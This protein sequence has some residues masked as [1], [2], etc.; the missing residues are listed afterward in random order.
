MM[1]LHRITPFIIGIVAAIGFALFFKY[2]SF[3][4]LW[5]I[6]TLVVEVVLFAHLTK[7]NIGKR[8]TLVLFGIP[9]V[10]ML[11]G[12][13]M[14]FFLQSLLIKILFVAVVS[15]LVFFFSEHIFYYLYLP[16]KYKA[17]AIEY[18]TLLI[19]VLCVFFISVAGFGV[20]LFLVAP[21]WLLALVFIILIL[22]II[23]SVMWV[24]KFNEFE[25]YFYSI[26]GSLILTELFISIIYLP[27]GFFTNAA[28]LT[29][30]FYLFI[31]LIRA[32]L[33]D[34][35]SKIVIRRYLLI[36]LIMLLGICVTS[37]WI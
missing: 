29:L 8:E 26:V 36:G 30:C 17:Y 18:V 20:R 6:I 22:F 14:A 37:K 32:Q 2:T 33:I 12:F 15:L 9:I 10:F 25:S 19:Q 28:I 16:S 11:S 34:Q 24:S 4:Y 1:I 5:M 3:Y 7:L 31:G 35:L 27:S 13:V 21:V 23:Y